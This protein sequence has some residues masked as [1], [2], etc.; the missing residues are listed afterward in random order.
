MMAHKGCD[1]GGEYSLQL[2]QTLED[3]DSGHLCYPHTSYNWEANPAYKGGMD[4]A[5]LGIP[6]W[7]IYQC[8][9]VLG[10]YCLKTDRK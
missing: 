4:G 6:C 7:E 5:S 1:Y 8:T 10:S 2:R 9:I 3:P